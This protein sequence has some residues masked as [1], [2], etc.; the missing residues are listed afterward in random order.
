MQS[1]KI[2]CEN[3]LELSYG[4][5]LPQILKSENAS[6]SSFHRTLASTTRR[7][8]RMTRKPELPPGKKSTHTRLHHSQDVACG[9]SLLLRPHPGPCTPQAFL[10]RAQVAVLEGE[11]STPASQHPEVSNE[12]RQNRK[13]KWYGIPLFD[14]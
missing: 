2:P 1:S 6:V 13:L 8:Q 11:H 7:I 3:L 9:P 4:K 5:K 10:K 12:M 14:V